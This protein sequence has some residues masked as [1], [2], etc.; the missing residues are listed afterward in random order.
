MNRGQVV[1]DARSR[2]HEPVDGRYFDDNPEM[3]TWYNQAVDEIQR[4]VGFEKETI[5]FSADDATYYVAALG[6]EP[7]YYQFPSNYMTI[8]MD[9]GISIDGIRRLGTSNRQIDMYQQKGVSEADSDTLYTDDYFQES[10]TGAI[11]HYV[12]EG[13][14]KDEIDSG[15]KGWLCYFQ[16]NPE[17]TSTIKIRFITLPA[18]ATSD[19]DAINIMRQFEEAL[20]IGLVKRGKEKQYNDGLIPYQS[21]LDSRQEFDKVVEEM[22]EFMADLVPDKSYK[23]HTA[24]QAFGMYKSAR[25]R[26]TVYGAANE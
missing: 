20:V 24:R 9:L 22:K 1:A 19:A 4:K 5:S 8:D 18:R 17:T 16:P 25:F 2:L 3:Y 12:V 23:I 21:L 15:R 14:L 7:R 10:Y 11:M 13:I 6:T 26:R